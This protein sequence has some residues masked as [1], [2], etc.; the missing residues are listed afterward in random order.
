MFIDPQNGEVDAF[1]EFEVKII[2]KSRTTY[3]D[4]I[5]TYNYALTAADQ[6]GAINSMKNSPDFKPENIHEYSI[7]VNV[8]EDEPMIMQ[9]KA[10]AVCPTI[11]LSQNTFKFGDCNSK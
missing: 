5:F 6:E 10:N 3:K 7:L 1:G 9:L 4:K 8:E 11:K 2:C